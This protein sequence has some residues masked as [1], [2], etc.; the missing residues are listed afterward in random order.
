MIPGIQTHIEGWTDPEE[1]R[2]VRA[3]GFQMARI[4]AMECSAVLMRDMVNDALAA[5]LI[6]FVT[7]A[8]HERLPLLA[9]LDVEFRNEDDGDL[10]PRAY[11]LLF[12]EACRMALETGVRMWGPTC[13]NTNRKCVRWASA[14]RGSG[15]PDGMHGLSWHSYDPHEN[16]EFAAVKALADGKPI[17]FS[18]FGYPSLGVSE[19]AQAAK[20]RELWPFYERFGAYAAILFQI[21]D[22][23]N[24]NEREHCYGIRRF[25]GDWKPAAY[26]VPKVGTIVPN[27]GEIEMNATFVI[28]RS[29]LIPNGA[30][31]FTVRYPSGDASQTVLSV[32]PD[33]AIETRPAGTTG[34][35]ETAHVDGSRLVFRDVNGKAWAF[36]L[37]D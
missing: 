33:G 19:E 31:A 18:E 34:A 9:G 27:A 35:W 16:T 12:D 32:Q 4:S 10:S 3:Q 25:Q 8:D 29:D 26:T 7:I 1:L 15:W 2:F 22:G 23:P 13:S 28:R 11:R 24:P 21:H 5:D 30:G 36:P 6:P 37:V 20:L 14:V 17:I